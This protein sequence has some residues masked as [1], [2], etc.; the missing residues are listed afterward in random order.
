MKI[1]ISNLL[2]P[3]QAYICE[4]SPRP[5]R[6]DVVKCVELGVVPGPMLGQLKSGHDVTLKDGRIVRSKDVVGNSSPA[7]SYLILDVPEV[8]LLSE[9]VPVMTLDACRWSIWRVW[10]PVTN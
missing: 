10:R 7:S 9:T 6:L 8:P 5:G 2:R 1:N 4:F 3:C